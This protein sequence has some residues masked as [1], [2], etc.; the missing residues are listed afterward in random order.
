MSIP[1]SF[2]PALPG[3]SS[4]S[5]LGDALAQQVTDCGRVTTLLDCLPTTSSPAVYAVD[6]SRPPLCHSTI[7]SFVSSFILP[8]SASTPPL[9]PN[10]RVMVVLPTGAANALALLALASY[11][12][13]APVNAS[14]TASELRE[15]AERLRARAVVTTR[16][17]EDRLQL[18]RLRAELGCEI[19]YIEERASGEAG[20]FDM[21][22]MDGSEGTLDERVPH[23]LPSRLHGLKDQSLVLHTSGTSGKKKVVPYT[24]RSLIIGTCAVV[25][26][27]DLK[28]DD[29]NMNM[30]PLFH[31]GGIVRNLFSPIMSGGAVVMSPGF[32]ATTFWNLAQSFGATWYY[33]APTMHHAILAS[34]PENVVP[35]KHTRIR[36]ICNAAGGLLPNLAIDLRDTFGG[37]VV[38]PS[39]GMTECMPIASPPT[40]Y[41]LD[42]PGCSGVACGPYLSIRDPLDRERELPCGQTGAVSVR[43]M[44]TFEG[45]ETSP[46]PGVPLDT[47]AFSSEGW[48]DSGDMGYVDA[49]G[50]LY[51]TGRSK[52]I[53]NKGG[54]VI[55]PFEIEE[56]IMLAAKDRV[57]T[58]LAFAIEHDVL[59]ETIGVVIVP[60]P[61]SNRISLAALLE[62]LKSQL[63]PSKWPFAVVYMDDV[64]KNQAGKPLRIK[65]GSRLGVGCLSDDVPALHRHF[66]AEVPDRETP[67][68]QPIACRKVA[69]DLPD[70]RKLL[71]DI[72]GVNDV[73]LRF[74]NDG[75]PE[76]F[77]SVGD[78]A[79][80]DPADIKT[81]LS[82]TLHDYSIPDK[83]HL[84]SQPLFK[85]G[86]GEIDF[87]AMEEDIERRNVS[88][89][90][91]RALVVRN[92]VAELLLIE[93]G[94]ITGESDFFLLG[95][96][97]LLLGRLM[98]FIRKETGVNVSMS[99]IF[100]KSTINGIA[101][102]I[103][104]E[105]LGGTKD[106][107]ITE[108]EYASSFTSFNAPTVSHGWNVP[109]GRGQNHPLSLLVQIIP[110]V[111]FYPMKA[112]LTWT[113]LLFILSYLAKHITNS[114]W[115]RMGS[116]LCAIVVARLAARVLP[117]LTAV[118][119]KW[120][121][122]GKYRPGTY[123]MWGNYHLRWWIV[124]QAI[125]AS[126]RGV[127]AVHPSFEKFYYR[128][129]GARIGKNVVIDRTSKL[130]EFDLLDFRDGCRIDRALVRG[131]CVER[132]GYF[133]LGH[134]VI[135]QNAV[136]N[137]YTQ[138][139]PGSVI[140]DGTVY[141]PHSSS[142][143]Q[144]S[145]RSYKN[146]NRTLFPQP[147]ILLK[148]FV[149]F[150]IIF[151]VKLVSYIP[152]FLAIKLMLARTFVTPPQ[153]NSVIKV[154]WWF[155]NPHRIGWHAL[156]RVIRAV[157]TPLVQ[158]IL[159]IVVKR[160]MGFNSEGPASEASQLTLLRRH[161][162]GVLLSQ[163][164]L[165]R[166]FDILGTHYEMTSIVFRL[167][168]AKVGKRVY[169][170]GS[171]IDCPDPELLE[172]GDD[173]VFGSRSELFTTDRIGSKKIRIGAGAMVADRCV[174][175][176]G[177]QVGR[178]AVLGSGSLARR[179]GVYEDNST[180]MGNGR[181]QAICL[182]HGSKDDP[183]SDTVTPFGRAFYGREANF[184][185]IPYVILVLINIVVAACSAAYWS[186][187]AVAAAQILRLWEL[188]APQLHLF[189]ETW[190]RFGTL[191]GLV[192]TCFIIV[193][194]LQALVAMIW[195]IVTKWIVIGRRRGGSYHWDQ[196]SYC[197]RWQLH[198]TL[199]RP[200][201]RGY[202]N[203]GPLAL[204]TG[205]A[206]IVW[207]FRALGA[208]IGK[209]CAIFAGG[210]VGLMTE[211]DLVELGDNVSLDNCS[212]VA[213]INSRGRFALNPLKISSG[214][215]LRSGSR[216]LSGASM[217]ENSML[218]EHTL[219]PS[220][221][222]AVS[223]GVYVGWPGHLQNESWDEKDFNNI[224]D[225]KAVTIADVK[226]LS[227]RASTIPPTPMTGTGII[228]PLCREFPKASVVT[229]CGH[230]YCESCIIHA[231][232]DE[233][234]CPVCSA[235]TRKK[236][237][238]PIY[239]SFRIPV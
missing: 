173:V 79:N 203:G 162:N 1:L 232:A 35:S 63:H 80:L 159:G 91:P 202:S 102:L 135:G 195:V 191:Y 172:I 60:Q 186:I 49:D 47:S 110:L 215:A 53:I 32:D 128:L 117:P 73:A 68:S 125:R 83:L 57:K 101:C 78:K 98:Y 152:W 119:F 228:C 118:L 100:A 239:L 133:R 27:W 8:T 6:A 207:F 165:K 3:P 161:I 192:A 103:D 153:A 214:C 67:L 170:P 39:Y 201:Y 208:K 184:F 199:S 143:A 210:R 55:S 233:H 45:Y 112:A 37:A 15:D 146:C 206:Y 95:G 16:S 14:C 126:G 149:A 130:G 178:R 137:T 11:H 218:L 223:G 5:S 66:E 70:I 154:I 41:A 113:F 43:G 72:D 99:A 196:S 76:A 158:L 75:S 138:I 93:P 131:F 145:H 94:S 90:S 148:L 108:Y 127:F 234:K 58:T 164:D 34:R 33:A 48:F 189:N 65:L 120:I 142:H 59:Q 56:A 238:T 25:K 97:S 85:S 71:S 139:A 220:G 21:H 183:N 52:E 88:S 194:P 89:M 74:G 212:V 116:L 129:L 87:R 230:V 64:P 219:L 213:H 235:E 9:G 211:P 204:I 38:L 105:E 10:D 115:E 144:P 2:L 44:P 231:L 86:A 96:N 42:R 217:E 84:F 132:D 226:V 13:C 22:T 92:I 124:N 168:G 62:S 51:I 167:M 18:R 216:L 29:V 185:V 140:A 171:G 31:V 156:A 30:M 160:V 198:L 123:P 19:V 36:M 24:L 225:S 155:A 229:E 46:D 122:I 111:F 157:F 221:D 107:T 134:I 82:R 166:A 20:L 209:N 227:R 4:G 180:W 114:F 190:Y 150:P 193:L 54:E 169:W 151:I 188:H 176:P 179:D 197:Q 40:N 200:L 181:G 187:S 50:Y 163:S 182:S 224:R 81:A 23:R 17:A 69:V 77:V 236:R 147:H 136:V 174:L 121:V 12:T 61:G 28:A 175:L 177:V 7:H 106:D 237:L 205:S 104:E 141:G 109:T 222:I 26:S